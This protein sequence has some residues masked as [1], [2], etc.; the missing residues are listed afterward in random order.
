ML[1]DFRREFHDYNRL[2]AES[3]R[4]NRRLVFYSER[5]IYYQYFDDYIQYVLDH[6]DIDICYITSDPADPVFHTGDS[7]IH[8]FYISN[9]LA[10][11]L[12]RLDAKALVMT[13]PDLDQYHIKRSRNSVNHIYLFHGVGSTHLQYN[14]DAFNAYDTI[15]CIGKYDMNEIRKAERLY[16]LPPKT[17]VECGYCRIEKIYAK[18]RSMPV[19]GEKTILIAPSW[20]NDNILACCADELIDALK[21]SGYR[22]IFRP[23]PEFIKRKRKLVDALAAKLQQIE[24][25]VLELDMV[26]DTS[27]HRADVLITDWSA[28]SYEYA[29]GTERPVLFINAPCK[30]HN[31]DYRE[32]EIEPIEFAV[33]SQIGKEIEV[34]EIVSIRPVLEEL[35]CNR[36]AYRRQIVDLRADCI[37]NWL[38]SSRAGGD[39]LIQ[40]CTGPVVDVKTKHDNL[41]FKPDTTAQ[42]TKS[43][44]A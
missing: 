25:M 26:S 34:G 3:N 2:F 14:K 29:F 9:F 32:L 8:P 15:F 21:N 39:Y 20:H 13:M 35:I 38:N 41:S 7:R 36:D 5:D 4:Q 10:S 11:A 37:S 42:R 43:G 23:H 18:H 30:I 24:N 19:A 17:L 40:C 12:A 44:K 31:Q 33:R 6:S 1:S 27:I 28:I 22:V 16:K